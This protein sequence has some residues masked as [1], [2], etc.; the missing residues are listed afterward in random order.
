[1]IAFKNYTVA[2]HDL[3]QAIA[4]HEAR[5]GMQK[6]GE[7]GHNTIGNFESQAMGYDGKVLLLLIQ[8]VPNASPI[9]KL[10]EERKNPLNPYG[11]GIYLVVYECADV[12]AFCKQIEAAGGRVTRAPGSTMAWVHPTASNF[13]LMELVPKR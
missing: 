2:V 10:M 1:M 8:P 9:H 11:E 4:D 5:F 3:A 12:E 13:V 6:I 7:R